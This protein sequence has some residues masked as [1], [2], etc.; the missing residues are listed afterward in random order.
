MSPPA[1]AG[2]PVLRDGRVKSISRGVLD[3]P[4]SRS[5]T[6]SVWQLLPELVPHLRLDLGHAAD[7][8]VVILGLLAHVTKYLRVRQDQ[9]R[10]LRE[11]GE[12]VFGDLLG[13]EVAVAGL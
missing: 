4:P 1:K 12:H 5:M 7:P 2:D 3:A 10:L 6:A 8:A 9:E 13:R 11:S